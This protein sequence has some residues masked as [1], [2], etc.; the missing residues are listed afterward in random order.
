MVEPIPN[1]ITMLSNHIGVKVYAI[2]A[3]IMIA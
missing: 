2:P 3:A 1:L